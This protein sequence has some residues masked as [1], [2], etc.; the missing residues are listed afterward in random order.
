MLIPAYAAEKK[1][2]NADKRLDASTEV[3]TEIMGTPDKSIPQDLLNKSECAIIV[4]G[5]KKGGFIIGGEYGRGF[6][7][8]R[9]AGRV[10]W[11]APGAP[12]LAERAVVQ[13]SEPAHDG[14]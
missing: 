14:N 1:Q 12:P 8:C 4:P 11:S 3:V 2:K 5:L 6:A 10:G 13:I 7:S 9:K